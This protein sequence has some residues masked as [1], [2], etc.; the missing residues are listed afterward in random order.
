MGSVYVALLHYPVY[1]RKRKPVTTSVTTMDLHDISRSCKTYGVKAYYIVQPLHTQCL[2]A[3]RIADYWQTGPGGK[4]NSNRKEALELLRVSETFEEMEEQIT[5]EEGAMP[6]YV[7][8]DAKKYPWSKSY[9]EVREQIKSSD[10]PFVILL[11][12]GDG[13]D[14]AV[15]TESDI[16]LDP[17]LGPT[18]YNHLSVRAAAAIIL[19]RLLR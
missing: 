9:Q 16:L 12:T 14:E 15:V 10:N 3:K 4:F 13:L 7:A 17:I 6:T 1:D 19:D 18:D 2:L 5:E 11:G 8:T